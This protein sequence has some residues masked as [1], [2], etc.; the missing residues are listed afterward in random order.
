MTCFATELTEHP[1][2]MCCGRLNTLIVWYIYQII[3]HNK[4]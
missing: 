3:A 2:T 1:K 4:R